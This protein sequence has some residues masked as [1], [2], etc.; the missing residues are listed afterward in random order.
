MS[1]KNLKTFSAAWMIVLVAVLGVLAASYIVYRTNTGRSDTESNRDT[2]MQQGK[3]QE[4][5][6]EREAEE[7][8]STGT[9]I[10][11]GDSEFGTMLFNNEGQAIYI[12]E[13]EGS[14]TAECY[15]DC[16]EAW[17][18]VLTNGTPRAMGGVSS[19]LLSTTRRTD[20]ST[21]VTYNGH[22][23]YYYAHEKAG[24]VKCHNVS[25]HG[26]L[27]WVIQPSGNRAK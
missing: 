10:T 17:P 21:Q 13:L 11:S 24:E 8:E 2:S 26:G 12:W 9:V 22:P 25:T 15:G 18:P 23:L 4:V 1:L 3:N 5:S 6:V 27:W 16:A 7:K 14:S 19:N 20:G